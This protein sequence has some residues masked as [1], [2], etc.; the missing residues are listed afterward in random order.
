MQ[1]REILENDGKNFTKNFK[2][3]KLGSLRS[4]LDAFDH[5]V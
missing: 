2:I 5:G 3:V 4:D 1:L